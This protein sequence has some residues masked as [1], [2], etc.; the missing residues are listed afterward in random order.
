[1]PKNLAEADFNGA[2]NVENAV[3]IE[4]G[5]RPESPNF[6]SLPGTFGDFAPK[7]RKFGL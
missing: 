7:L 6:K 4:P 2:R 3:Q 5:F 1:L